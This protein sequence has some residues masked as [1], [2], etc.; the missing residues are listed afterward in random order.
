MRTVMLC[1]PLPDRRIR[2]SRPGPP[3]WPRSRPGVSADRA[4]VPLCLIVSVAA[5]RPDVRRWVRRGGRPDADAGP[6]TAG[7]GEESGRAMTCQRT[8]LAECRLRAGAR[9]GSRDT[10][11]SGASTLPGAPGV[12][13][14][15]YAANRMGGLGLRRRPQPESR[16]N[17]AWSR[18]HRPGFPIG[19]GAL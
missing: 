10:P 7:R 16:A 11:P 17:S 9:G 14:L 13:A 18:S 19:S 6:R 5:A 3:A 15:Q 8:R 4:H 1:L 2:V 12:S